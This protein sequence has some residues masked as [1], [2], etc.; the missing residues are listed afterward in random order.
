MCF[1]GFMKTNTPVP[2]YKGFRFPPE[3]ISHAVWLYFCFSLRFRDGKEL[4]APRGIGVTYETVREC[5]S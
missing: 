1:H 3:I 4:L 5:V 2:S